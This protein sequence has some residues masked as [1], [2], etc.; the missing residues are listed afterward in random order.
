MPSRGD[1]PRGAHAGDLGKVNGA[2]TAPRSSWHSAWLWIAAVIFVLLCIVVGRSAAAQ[3][4]RGIQI[5][6]TAMALQPDLK[7]GAALYGQYCASCHGK[8]AWGDGARVIP[9]LAGQIPLYLVKQLVDLAE[10]D[11]AVPEMHRLIARQPLT[12]PQVL[13]NVATYLSTLPRNGA[14]EVGAGTQLDVG[15][16]AY[17]GFCSYCHGQQ[18]EGNAEHATP[19]LQ[20]QHYSYL[21]MQTRQLAV[22]HRYS[23]DVRVIEKLEL[24]PFEYVEA[25]ADYAARLPRQPSVVRSSPEEDPRAAAGAGRRP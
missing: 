5:I 24:L 2:I 9:A 1:F 14:P 3:T 15:Q 20:R 23:V 21:L 25:V 8:E 17:E 16:R 19:A 7:R 22:G 10:G 12:Q 18:G 4:K 6:E 13:R 11:R